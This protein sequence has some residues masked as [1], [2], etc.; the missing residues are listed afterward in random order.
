MHQLDKISPEPPL[1]LLIE[2][3]FLVK[4]LFT[5]RKNS[6]VYSIRNVYTKNL[7]PFLQ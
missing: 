6:H 4:K 7:S 5:N 3:R 2:V 1:K